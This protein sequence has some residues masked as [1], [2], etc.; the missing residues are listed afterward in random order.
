MKTFRMFLK[1]EDGM[2]PINVAILLA[3]GV[4]LVVVF[5]QK[6]IDLWKPMSEQIDKSTKELSKSPF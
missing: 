6:I 3:I 2:E 4:G 1:E 5:R